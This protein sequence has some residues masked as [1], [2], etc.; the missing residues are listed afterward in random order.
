[1]M[2]H[3]HGTTARC[4]LCTALEVTRGGI[5]MHRSTAGLLLACCFAAGF[6]CATWLIAFSIS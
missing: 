2:K 6:T 1:M 4:N 5:R 3:L